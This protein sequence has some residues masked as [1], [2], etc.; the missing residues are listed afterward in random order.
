MK[1]RYRHCPELLTEFQIL[2]KFDHPHIAKIHSLERDVT[3]IKPSGKKS[4]QTFMVLELIRGGELFDYVQKTELFTDPISRY[5][6][7]QLLSA[8]DAVH[9]AGFCHGDLKPGNILFDHNFNLKLTDFGFSR[10]LV[11]DDGFCMLTNVWGTRGYMAPEIYERRPY[12]G[13]KSDIFA[14]GVILFEMKTQQRPF[15]FA[16]KDCHLY[17]LFLEDK[18]R[19]WSRVNRRM[20]QITQSK[21]ST[22]DFHFIEL[23]NG[24]L[25]H[26]PEQRF[27][28]KQIRN[29]PYLQGETPS[30]YT[31]QKEFEKRYL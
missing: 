24:M 8:V 4:Q 13:T 23:I 25:H 12:D 19:F 18:E 31:I 16:S 14:A 20:C 26:D 27:T 10:P 1:N 28:L 9:E 15:H 11:D 22:L 6:F 29:H 17:A 30:H 3:Q 7:K 5:F 2:K 21:K